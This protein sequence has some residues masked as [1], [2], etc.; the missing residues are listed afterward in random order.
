MFRS[1]RCGWR[2]VEKMIV[3]GLGFTNLVRTGV[4][5]GVCLCLGCSGVSSVSG[6][7]VGGLDQ[8]LEGWGGLCLCEM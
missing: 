1:E 4:V 5:M 3:L 2:G 6:E 7:W 8:D